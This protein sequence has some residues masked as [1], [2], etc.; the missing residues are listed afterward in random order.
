MQRMQGCVF[1]V[2]HNIIRAMAEF[3][4]VFGGIKCPPISRE[5]IVNGCGVEDI[6][7]G[8]NYSRTACVIVVAK[9]HDTFEAFLH[10]L[11]SRLLHIL[12][13]LLPISFYILQMYGG[14]GEHHTQYVSWSIHNKSRAGLHQF[15]DSFGGT[16]HSNVCNDP[17][18]IV[19]SQTNLQEK[20]DTKPQQ[21]VE[22]CSIVSY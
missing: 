18:A 8:T 14:L 1:M 15:L 19:L 13:R 21:V 17:T 7:D 3:C 16:E 5:E 20:E 10:Q 22:A 6:Y 11:G 9:A 12:K 2:V 4:F